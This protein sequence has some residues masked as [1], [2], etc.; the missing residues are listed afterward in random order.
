MRLV[1]RG[2]SSC[3][4]L[5]PWTPRTRHGSLRRG[6][7][8]RR[9]GGGAA[10]CSRADGVKGLAA[11]SQRSTGCPLSWRRGRIEG[12]VGAATGVLRA[13]VG[14]CRR[15]SG[16]PGVPRLG[17]AEPSA[18]LWASMHVTLRGCYCSHSFW[19]RSTIRDCPDAPTAALYRIA[20]SPPALP[21]PD[22]AASKIQPE[23][24][25][26]LVRSG[27]QLRRQWPGPLCFICKRL[28]ASRCEH[29][30]SSW[31]PCRLTARRRS[32]A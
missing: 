30:C 20:S 6:R 7:L 16:R 2:S 17:P 31:Q 15:R 32:A 24:Q 9:R 1:D 18:D 25:Q 8:A 28:H 22:A 23:A 26:H 4:H 13:A 11:P 3:H 5:R 14:G 12:G 29:Q 10:S 21:A 27:A 19:L